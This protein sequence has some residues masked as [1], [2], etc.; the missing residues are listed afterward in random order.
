MRLK[1]PAAQVLAPSTA[2]LPEARGKQAQQRRSGCI[3]NTSFPSANPRHQQAFQQHGALTPKHT[4]AHVQQQRAA[5][6]LQS[7]EQL[8]SLSVKLRTS[9]AHRLTATLLLQGMTM[10]LNRLDVY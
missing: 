3:V 1:A 6:R 4:H 2:S 9:H 7:S 10:R 5:A 8:R